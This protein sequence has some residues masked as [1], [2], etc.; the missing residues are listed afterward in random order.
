VPRDWFATDGYE[1][2]GPV[3]VPTAGSGSAST[4]VSHGQAT[5]VS[6]TLEMVGGPSQASVDP[7]AGL[8]SAVDA[9]GNPVATTHADAGGHFSFALRP[10]RYQLVA[11]SPNYGGGL[12]RCESDRAIVV[13]NQAVHGVL[14][15]CQRK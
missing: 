4:V 8:V 12:G 14:V 9:A 6:G 11:R 3:P 15:L 5:A 1:D 7:V 2:L 13:G 10:G